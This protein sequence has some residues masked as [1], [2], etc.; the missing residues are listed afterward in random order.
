MFKGLNRYVLK[1]NQGFN[2]YVRVTLRNILQLDR[3]CVTIV[4]VEIMPWFIISFDVRTG[5]MD[6]P[7]YG[8]A[9]SYTVETA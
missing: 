1:N 4:T 6:H 5:R 9:G 2:S 7:A 8:C 3:G